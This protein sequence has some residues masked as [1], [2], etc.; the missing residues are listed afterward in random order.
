MGGTLCGGKE[1][2]FGTALVT[3]DNGRLLHVLGGTLCGGKESL[4]GTALVTND[5]DM[6]PPTCLCGGK[7][8]GGT[9]TVWWKG[10]LVWHR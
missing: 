3:N 2:L 9:M 1:S 4:F 8:L 6:A 5:N 7:E 10:V